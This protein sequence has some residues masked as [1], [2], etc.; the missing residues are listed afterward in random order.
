M[1]EL[2]FLTDDSEKQKAASKYWEF[3]SE[4]GNF[5]YVV[6]AI[7]KDLEIDTRKV[8]QWVKDYC[9]AFDNEFT[10][11]NCNK[12]VFHFTSRTE[13]VEHYRMVKYGLRKAFPEQI[14]EVCKRKEELTKEE[15]IARKKEI[16]DQR[17][18]QEIA[19]FKDKR[20]VLGL[21]DLSLENA[22]YLDAYGRIGLSEN[23]ALLLSLETITT[24]DQV[25]TPS[26]KY[27]VDIVRDLYHRG[28]LQIH[29]NNNPD[30]ISEINDEGF[31]FS[32]TTTNWYFPIS[33]ENLQDHAS[34][35]KKIEQT[36]QNSDWPKSWKDQTLPLWKKIAT[37]EC[38]EY[39][40]FVLTEH[41]LKFTPGEK[42]KSLFDSLLSRYSTGQVFNWIWRAGRDAA[43]FYVRE[44]VS[45]QHAA[46]TVVGTIQRMA[47]R[48][49]AENWN[50]KAFQRNYQL[51]QSIVSQVLYNAVLKIGESGFNTCPFAL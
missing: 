39:L 9:I 50:V 24:A 10:C 14:C 23:Y 41:T 51:P 43:A 22:V 30:I 11:S 7:A 36:F 37:W 2:Y 19:K 20:P 8:S 13:Y 27:D 38:L 25:L 3:D 21:E 47:E 28:F 33:H 42:T 40:D 34:L 4:T 45:K 49:E 12:P 46:N 16:E 6:R 48:A 15:E 29:A 31:R 26:G 18:A 1:L 5:V 44:R 17:K 32:L 35:F